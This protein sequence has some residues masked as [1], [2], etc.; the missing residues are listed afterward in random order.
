MFITTDYMNII[1][2]FV[3]NFKSNGSHVISMTAINYIF[4]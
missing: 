2:N 4:V 1:A 3:G